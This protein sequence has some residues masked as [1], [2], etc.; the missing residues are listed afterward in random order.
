LLA[1]L[2]LTLP[3]TAVTASPLES[4][5][6]FTPT[7]PTAPFTLAQGPEGNVWFTNEGSTR[8]GRVTQSCEVTEFS[9]GLSSAAYGIVA[10]PEGNVWFTEPTANK[11]GYIDPSE[12]TT[13]LVE[14]SVPSM[15]TS[16]YIT[17]GPDGNLWFTLGSAG[18]GRITPSGVVS[19]FPI[20]GVNACSITT[21]PD[22]TIW[23]GSCGTPR[24]V[25][26][27]TEGIVEPFE[28][29]G[30]IASQP[31]SIA[32]GSDGRAWVPANKSTTERIA[33]VSPS[34]V[35]TYYP[36]P[37]GVSYT[38]LTAGPDGNIWAQNRASANEKQKVTIEAIENLD[39]TFRLSWE[40]QET[41]S[42]SVDSPPVTIE[43]ELG[44]LPGLPPGAVKVGRT[45][46]PNKVELTLEFVGKL[47]RTDVPTVGCNGG[48]LTGAGVACTV[49][50]I[51]IAVPMRLFRI[52][53]WGEF[54]EFPLKPSTVLSIAKANAL[55]A[56]SGGAL[57]YASA[58]DAAMGASPAIGRFQ[59]A[60]PPGK[61]LEV[62]VIGPGKVVG[63]GIDCLPFC[64]ADIE[65]GT[66]VTLTAMPNAGAFFL[67]WK[68]CESVN[69]R[70]CTAT[71][72]AA[73]AITATFVAAPP[74]TVS[75]APGSG[76]GKVTSYPGGILCLANCST[77][78]AGFKEGAKVKLNQAPSKHSHFVEWLGDCTGSGTCEVTMGEEHEVEALFAEDPRYS[79]SL[80]KA[81]GGQ[82]TVKSLPSGVNCGYTCGSME[83]DF[84]DGTVVVLTAAV[85]AGK[86]STF[87]GWSGAGCSGTGTCT[88]TMDEAKSVTAEF[89]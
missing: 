19:E 31:N 74:L 9:P 78:T 41:A 79:L 18:L 65:E 30:S 51:A 26:H 47:A 42:I 40:G 23:L 55:A 28:V 13:S 58:G 81:G 4:Q 17:P 64:S 53:P 22:G 37:V 14:F 80:A 63:P 20:A 88:V 48:G 84:Y 12:P 38:S 2:A 16:S 11:V 6:C 34:G 45:D 87:A 49:E 46:S 68:N 35:V 50:T 89:E 82:G 27:F 57:W 70:Q 59:A 76:Q 75:K 77:T 54:T 25:V 62:I 71:M 32:I 85:Q 52:T 5:E 56:G 33:A 67:G 43:S 69:G 1:L 8:I 21:G 44:A 83:V 66:K 3:A 10:G 29:A 72:S 39:G 86:G 15:P 60:P 61:S 73:R 7:E 36:T 24:K